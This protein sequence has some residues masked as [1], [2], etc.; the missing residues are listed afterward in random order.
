MFGFM[1]TETP[2]Q[3]KV[4]KKRMEMRLRGEVQDWSDDMKWSPCMTIRAKTFTPPSLF[5][6]E[7]TKRTLVNDKMPKGQCVLSPDGEWMYTEVILPRGSALNCAYG[8]KHGD[9]C[10][11]GDVVIPRIHQSGGHDNRWP[12]DPWMSITPQEILTMR[13]GT[14]FAKGSTVLA[15]LGMGHQLEQ[16]C[17]RKQVKNVIVVEREQ[18]LVD[19][20]LPQLDLN[21]KDVEVVI[22]DARKLVPE[23]TATSALIDIYKSYGYNSFRRCPSIKKV[24]VWG[25]ARLPDRGCW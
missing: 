20:V 18:G 2:A 9:I 21:G 19:W 12:G 14:R 8:A 22:G 10:F 11:D 5:K 15:G 7:P 13:C 4:K 16:V 23:M 1:F 17:K 6:V 3:K 24:W 25:S